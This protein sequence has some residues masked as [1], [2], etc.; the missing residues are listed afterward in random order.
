LEIWGM[1]KRAPAS[2]AATS[3]V[4][5]LHIVHVMLKLLLVREE[6]KMAAGKSLFA[7]L[8]FV[9]IEHGI[10]EKVAN[11][12][13]SVNSHLLAQKQIRAENRVH[14]IYPCRRPLTCSGG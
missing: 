1:L 9:P 7:N 5:G 13:S 10:R 8:P 11:F 14:G 3:A 6:P 4:R 12:V 2:V